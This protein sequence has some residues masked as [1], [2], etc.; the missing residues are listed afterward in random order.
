MLFSFGTQGMRFVLNHMLFAKAEVQHS[1]TVFCHKVDHHSERTL[2]SMSQTQ[3][4]FE[5]NPD[6]LDEIVEE[7]G[8]VRMFWVFAPL[9]LLAIAGV[10]YFIVRRFFG[11]S[12]T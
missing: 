11:S 6:V 7:T 3:T 4:D 9:A 12:D 10:A 2:I 8:R 5:L 1:C